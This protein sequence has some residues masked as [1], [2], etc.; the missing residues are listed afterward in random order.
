MY[1][2]VTAGLMAKKKEQHIS[3]CRI[4]QHVNFNKDESKVRRKERTIS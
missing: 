1:D 3:Q 4:K 2:I